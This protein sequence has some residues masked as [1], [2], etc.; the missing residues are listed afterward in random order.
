MP[1]GQLLTAEWQALREGGLRRHLPAAPDQVFT[2]TVKLLPPGQDGVGVR[3]ERG[4]VRQSE[5][6]KLHQQ[7]RIAMCEKFNSAGEIDY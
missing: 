6:E 2:H 1:S 7:M 5:E 3:T 4:S